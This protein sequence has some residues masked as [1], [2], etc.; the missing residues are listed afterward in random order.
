LIA[1]ALIGSSTLRISSGSPEINATGS[2]GAPQQQMIRQGH[3]KGRY[4][5]FSSAD[6]FK[7]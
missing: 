5:Y 1:K 6:V 4:F 2:L 3:M 7:N